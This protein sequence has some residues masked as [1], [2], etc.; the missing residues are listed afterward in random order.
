MQAC[1]DI[2]VCPECGHIQ[3]GGPPALLAVF[4]IG[5]ELDADGQLRRLRLCWKLV[6][7]LIALHVMGSILYLFL[8]GYAPQGSWLNS[9]FHIFRDG[10]ALLIAIGVIFCSVLVWK[11][12]RPRDHL[13]PS[14]YRKITLG[15][16]LAAI[17]APSIGF[18]WFF[19]LSSYVSLHPYLFAFVKVGSVFIAA[20]SV[21]SILAFAAYL[22]L[23]VVRVPTN[24]LH[25][26]YGYSFIVALMAIAALAVAIFGLGS[27]FTPRQPG[28]FAS[29]S[30]RLL[31]I[32]AG[33]G[34]YWA[35][36]ILSELHR[37]VS[38]RASYSACEEQ[39]IT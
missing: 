12:C 14:M 23:R 32:L 21:L 39:S 35:I 33:G 31:F 36:G 15:R 2:V 34:W 24:D 11:I 1:S 28:S 29:D 27:V 30:H 3:T 38:S 6:F 7:A 25:K 17:G 8:S 20:T 18:F 19:I 13:P 16:V 26:Q 5:E 10:I 37:H 22:A 4:T 9:L